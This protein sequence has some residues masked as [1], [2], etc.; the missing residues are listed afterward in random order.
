V[1][2]KESVL[3]A[4]PLASSL[5]EKGTII[6]AR[7]NTQLSR[8]VQVTNDEF[9]KAESYYTPDGDLEIKSYALNLESVTNGTLDAPSTHDMELDQKVEQIAR[10]VLRHISF[11]RNVVKPVVIDF[12]EKLEIRLKAASMASPADDFNIK[13][14]Q[15]PEL[16]QDEVFKS[17]VLK[18]DSRPLRPDS[19]I[20]F[21]SKTV[22][23]INA[24]MLTGDKD[25]DEAIVSWQTR[26]GPD[27]V[28]KVWHSFF[29]TDVLQG[30]TD[31]STFALDRLEVLPT[32]FK[33]D[34]FLA[35]YLLASKLFDQTEEAEGKAA[36]LAAYQNLV[37]QLRDYA[38]ATLSFLV[39][40]SERM[41]DLEFLVAWID[42]EK[43]EIQVLKPIYDQWLE[44]GGK[45]EVLLG[46][47]V[48]NKE[49]RSVLQINATAAELEQIW[50]SHCAYYN[51]I[52]QN[53]MFVS[54]K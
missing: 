28:L 34:I 36:S 27:D 11:T 6:G 20:N 42:R 46:L 30:V 50:N 31:G 41:M 15:L 5:A 2:N 47:L 14:V 26:L 24:L 12:R 45:P 23:E 22:D 13:S 21:P 40:D 19:F 52:G 44:N 8:L 49:L 4:F 39:K 3:A 43:K 10:A 9:L 53:K 16:F 54:T 51:N 37:A 17:Q 32:F 7:E 38:G 25:Q 29:C 48:S 1:I 18:F 35:I 33:A